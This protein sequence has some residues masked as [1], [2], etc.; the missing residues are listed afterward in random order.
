MIEKLVALVPPPYVH[1]SR[2]FGVLSSHS[3]WRRQ[4]V[5]RPEVKK[6]FVAGSARPQRMTWSRL[7]ARVFK[8]DISRCR[9]C[10]ARMNPEDC[11]VV[12]EPALVSAIL[13]ALGLAMHPPARGPPHGSPEMNFDIDQREAYLDDDT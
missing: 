1:L 9:A 3:R 8:I 6:G 13:A 2:Y 5:L 11:E 10:S 4:I 12:T 7:L